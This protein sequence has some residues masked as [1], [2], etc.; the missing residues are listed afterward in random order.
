MCRPRS[1]ARL[2]RTAWLIQEFGELWI[3]YPEGG[4][5]DNAFT[6]N[7]GFTGHVAEH[8]AAVA[9]LVPANTSPRVVVFGDDS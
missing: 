7:V 2:A 4:S 6:V 1:S 3:T 8:S 9:A 5:L